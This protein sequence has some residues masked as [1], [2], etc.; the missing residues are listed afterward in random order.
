MILPNIYTLYL[1]FL[2]KNSVFLTT[3][4]YLP[5]HCPYITIIITKIQKYVHI[6]YFISYFFYGTI[7]MIKKVKIAKDILDKKALAISTLAAASV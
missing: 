6:S 4:F 1:Y 5:A 7:F 2:I 3:K